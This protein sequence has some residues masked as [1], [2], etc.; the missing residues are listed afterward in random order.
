M[1]AKLGELPEPFDYPLDE[2][3]MCFLV[4]LILPILRMR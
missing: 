1:C 3:V 2:F 4:H